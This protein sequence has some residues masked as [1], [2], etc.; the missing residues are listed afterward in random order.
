MFSPDSI[1]VRRDLHARF[2]GQQQGGISTPSRFPI[3][4]LFT[5]VTGEA[6]GYT[7]GW[8][9]D[10]SFQYSGEGQVGDMEFVRGNKAIRNHSITDKDV[11]LFQSLRDG[12]VRYIGQFEY[13]EHERVSGVPDRAGNPREAILFRLR[14]IGMLDR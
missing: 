8:S 11:H 9:A 12:K 7:D 1:H 4:F 13:L 14:P 3:I 10:G 6:F 2:G 5:G